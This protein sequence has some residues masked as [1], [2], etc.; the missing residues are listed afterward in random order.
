LTAPGEK[1]RDS[2]AIFWL[3]AKRSRQLMTSPIL[4]RLLD[5]GHVSIYRKDI[6]QDL[7]RPEWK[8]RATSSR[9]QRTCELAIATFD[10]PQA[11]IHRQFSAEKVVASYNSFA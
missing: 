10:W 1:K 3:V 4:R 2:Q 7:R 11:Q 6:L 8:C 9:P 5:D